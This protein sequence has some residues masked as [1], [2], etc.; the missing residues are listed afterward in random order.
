MLPTDRSVKETQLR[1]EFFWGFA[2]G[3]AST[4]ASLG[5]A[6]ALYAGVSGLVGA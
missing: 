1:S 2:L 4:F 6:L 5:L 3:C